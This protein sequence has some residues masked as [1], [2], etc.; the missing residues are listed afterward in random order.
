MGFG[1]VFKVIFRFAFWSL[2]ILS[3]G[4][5]LWLT[6]SFSLTGVAKI[7]SGVN[8]TVKATSIT[9]FVT[10]VTFLVGRY[11]EQNRDKN[12]KLN[13]EKVVVY[14]KFFD[15]YFSLF[16]QE[17]V[18]GKARTD[19]EILKEMLDFQ[20]DAFFWG[21]DAVLQRYLDFKEEMVGF[22][23]ST[24]SLEEEEQAKRLAITI[25]S[26]ARLFAAM[27]RDIGYRFT[28][29]SPHDLGRLQLADDLETA[30]IFKYLKKSA[31]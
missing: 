31:A 21:S 9:A 7:F 3:A 27:R 14:K 13:V 16:N 10:V 28:T 30:R 18:T 5:L 20:V 17:K 19:K 2:V 15:F 1:N 25:T 12:A 23:S 6:A 29:F 26:A 11:F 4:Y 24:K 8:D 22:S